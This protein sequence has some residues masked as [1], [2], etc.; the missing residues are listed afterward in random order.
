MFKAA[1]L[2]LLLLTLAACDGGTAGGTPN[3]GRYE[4]RSKI[5]RFEVP[6]L[7]PPKLNA[8]Q[9]VLV[10]KESKSTFCLS[11]AAAKS[12]GEALFQRIGQGACYLHEFNPKGGKVDVLMTCRAI[13][14]RQ[15]YSLR[16]TISGGGATVKASG[17][18]TNQRFPKGTAQVDR[19]VSMKR[20]ADCT[21][22]VVKPKKK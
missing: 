14:G 1:G 20:I 7:D 6:G 21:P 11:D 12:K 13:S 9:R 18:V 17:M 2:L 19:E 4:I 15:S 10:G 3:A 8:M 22:P 16:G 5:T